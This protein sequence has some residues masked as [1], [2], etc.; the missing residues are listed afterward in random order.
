MVSGKTPPGRFHRW[1]Y[2]LLP[3]R[4]S[5]ATPAPSRANPLSTVARSLLRPA[6]RVAGLTALRALGIEGQI[7]ATGVVYPRADGGDLEQVAGGDAAAAVDAASEGG[8]NAAIKRR[9]KTFY[10]RFNSKKSMKRK[11]KTNRNK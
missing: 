8:S 1:T 10:R 5:C 11:N 3:P 9:K 4:R 6:N 2:K 7:A